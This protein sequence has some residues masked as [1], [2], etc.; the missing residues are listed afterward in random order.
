MKLNES[1][2]KKNE[3]IQ[4]NTE[5]IL[6]YRYPMALTFEKNSGRCFIGDSLG[7]VY[8]WRIDIHSDHINVIMVNKIEEAEIEGDSI[9]CINILPNLP[10]Y[11]FVHSRDNCIREL[12]TNKNEN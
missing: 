1:M 8:E 4:F 7:T 11:I 5:N 2:W 9:N 3:E 10:K 12:K 6:D